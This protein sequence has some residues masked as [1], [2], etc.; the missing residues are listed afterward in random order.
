MCPVIFRCFYGLAYCLFEVSD[1]DHFK[2]RVEE[3]IAP[4]VPH[5]RILDVG[6]GTGHFLAVAV[7]H[8]YEVCG[9]EPNSDMVQYAKSE[10]KIPNMHCGTLAD[11]MYPAASFDVVTIWDVLEHVEQPGELLKDIARV[12]K[13][14][15]WVFAYT[16]NF[17]SFNVFVTREYSEIVTPEVHLRH[18][19]PARSGGNSSKLAFVSRKSTLGVWILPIFERP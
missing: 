1:G 14:G 19:S 16:E 5:G 18:Y 17:E 10:L 8:G 7:A 6:C 12:L 4:R 9:V 13:P 2:E 15:G 11:A 3:I